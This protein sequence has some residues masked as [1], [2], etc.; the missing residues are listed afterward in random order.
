MHL[1][2]NSDGQIGGELQMPIT[3]VEELASKSQGLS[4]GDKP[5]GL[6]E[7]GTFDTGFAGMR[8][9]SILDS[10]GQIL[11]VDKESGLLVVDPDS[12]DE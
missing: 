9:H 3:V 11:L 5:P 12:I 10:N 4:V 8:A 1:P 6:A 7:D 2:T